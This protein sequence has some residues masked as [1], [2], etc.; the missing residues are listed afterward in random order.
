[1]N[2]KS[3]NPIASVRVTGNE[4]HSKAVVPDKS[5]AETIKDHRSLSSGA[6]RKVETKVDQTKRLSDI[7]IH[8][9]I[10]DETNHLIVI[11]TDR[12]TGCV[13]RTIPA[14]EFEKL[15]AGDLLKLTA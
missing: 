15:Q 9:N 10:D 8:F 2:E 12:Q 11:V 1:M 3:L 4:I 7:A 6:F 14:S 13:L 5:D